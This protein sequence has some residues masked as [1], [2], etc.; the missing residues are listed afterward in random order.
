VVVADSNHESRMSLPTNG[1]RQ[2]WRK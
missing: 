2:G 1:M